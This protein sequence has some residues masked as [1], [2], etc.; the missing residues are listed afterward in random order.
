MC[1]TVVQTR[2]LQDDRRVERRGRLHA[3]VGGGGR[4][5][6]H[7][8]DGEAELLRGLEE[9][10]H[11][12]STSEPDEAQKQRRNNTLLDESCDTTLN[13][14]PKE[15][16]NDITCPRTFGCGVIAGEREQQSEGE[17]SAVPLQH[18]VFHGLNIYSSSTADPEDQKNIS[19]GRTTG[20]RPNPSTRAGEKGRESG[21]TL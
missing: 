3:A 2:H 10:H 15:T 12:S 4:S 20:E 21:E 11:L 8:G 6:V 5:D 16:P 9:L 18:L 1:E 19:L 7:G 17:G 14:T 13:N